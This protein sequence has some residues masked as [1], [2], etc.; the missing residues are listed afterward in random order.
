MATIPPP[1]ASAKSISLIRCP[2]AFVGCLPVCLPRE[3]TGGYSTPLAPVLKR[4]GWTM[5]EIIDLL[6]AATRGARRRVSRREIMS[7]LADARRKCGRYAGKPAPAV[8]T[9]SWPDVDPGAIAAIT[10][11]WAGALRSLGIQPGAL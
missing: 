1:P 5:F 8:F 9:K 2:S 10:K 4:Q 6:Y 11:N 7:A 3:S